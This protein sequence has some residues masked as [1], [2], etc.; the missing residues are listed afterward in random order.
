NGK[1]P[2]GDSRLYQ[3]VVSESA[4]LIWKLRNERVINKPPP[5]HTHLAKNGLYTGGGQQF[6]NDTRL[7]AY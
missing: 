3:I 7:T 6:K 2:L 1:I 5:T 4:H